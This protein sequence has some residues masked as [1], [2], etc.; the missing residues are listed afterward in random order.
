M[1][2]KKEEKMEHILDEVVP[3]D[4]LKKF[5]QKYHEEMLSGQVTTHDLHKKIYVV[6]FRVSKP[7][8]RTQTICCR[9]DVN[10]NTK[11]EVKT[12]WGSKHLLYYYARSMSAKIMCYGYC[13]V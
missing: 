10:K 11:S 6:P 2:L 13:K 7:L 4:E 8:M 3:S 1:L 9:E 5:E 12:T